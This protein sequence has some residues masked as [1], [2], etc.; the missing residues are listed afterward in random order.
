MIGAS[1]IRLLVDSK[2]DYSKPKN[3]ILTSTVFT[4]G[5]SGISIQLGHIKFTGMVLSSAVAVFMSL[6]FYLFEKI[7]AVEA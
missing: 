7:N 4:T 1:G 6:I 5:L 2:I 3:L